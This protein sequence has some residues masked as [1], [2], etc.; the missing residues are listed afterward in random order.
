MTKA[1]WQHHVLGQ[2]DDALVW[3]CLDAARLRDVYADV[4]ELLA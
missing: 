2:L 1:A 4:P 3:C